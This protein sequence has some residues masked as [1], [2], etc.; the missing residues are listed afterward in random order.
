MR[1]FPRR[2]E[3]LCE[4]FQRWCQHVRLGK[5]DSHRKHVEVALKTNDST[6]K[7]I[8]DT[9]PASAWSARPD[10]LID[11]F[12]EH[13]LDY[14]GLAKNQADFWDFYAAVHPDD[15]KDLTEGWQAILTSGRTGE[16]EARLR[17][18]DGNYRWFLLR[19][20]PLRDESGTIV[21]W[22]GVNTDINERKHAE[23][24]LSASERNL[25]LLIDTIPAL[26]W[27]ARLDGTADFLNQHYLEPRR[28]F[29]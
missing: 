13:Y 11:F 10:G 28:L 8:I 2:A 16:A 17:R 7:L 25:Q 9:V 3:S 21:K 5:H 15:L 22:Y 1:K 12:N 26:A 18:F 6:L 23:E 19:A 27:S 24:A 20:N 14:V 4:Q 29:S